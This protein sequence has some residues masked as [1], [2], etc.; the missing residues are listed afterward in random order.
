MT[1]TIEIDGEAYKLTDDPSLRTVRKV[2]AM[3]M[4][5]IREYVGEE[6]LREMD[7]LEDEG[8]I[9]QAI[10]DSGGYE[11]F[12]DVMW[13]RSLLEPIQ[14]I[15][16]AV[17][18]SLDVDSV[19]DMGAKEFEDAKDKAEEALGGTADDFFKRLGIGMSLASEM[20]QRAEQ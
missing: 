1:D 7:S 13:E 9:V 18:E 20:E 11:A 2:Q 19:E 15:S 16:L 4:N 8:E 17:D 5:M 10:L 3:Q 6:Q 12:Q 14:T